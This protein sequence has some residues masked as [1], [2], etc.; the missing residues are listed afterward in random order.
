MHKLLYLIRAEPDFERVVALAI[1]GKDQFKQTFIFAGDVFPFFN[2]GI[3][4]QFQKYLFKKHGFEIKDLCDYDLIG[5]ILKKL[6]LKKNIPRSEIFCYTNRKLLIPGIFLIILQKYIKF[7]QK[8][9]I[10]K[11]LRKV[12]PNALL[13]DMSQTMKDYTPEVFRR[14]ALE[15]KIPSCIFVH[16][17]AGGLHSAFTNPEYDPYEGYY[18]FICSN[19]ETKPKYSNRII[20][21]DMSSSY[22]YV[23]YINNINNSTLSFLDDRKYKIAFMQSGV[24]GYSTSTNAWSIME[25]IIINLSDNSDVAIVIKTHP[26]GARSAGFTDFGMLSTFNN[27]KIVGPECDRSRVVKWADIVVCSDHCSTIFEPMILGKKVVAIEGIHIPKYKDK[28][29]PIK[30]SSVK[31]ITSAKEFRLNDLPNVNPEDPVTNSICW[32]NHGK[33]DLARLFLEKVEEIIEDAK[34]ATIRRYNC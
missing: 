30:Y 1:S 13:T 3:Q 24:V 6:S 14:R 20:L 18:V 33:A 27:V 34:N 9:I 2:N 17:A 4:D 12:K 16:G 19:R 28:H 8:K 22:P 23:N 31:H 5:N 7:K 25:E 32:G 15:M 26:R 11:I 10:K 21:G 29:S